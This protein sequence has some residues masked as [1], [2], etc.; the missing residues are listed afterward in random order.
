MWYHQHPAWESCPLWDIPACFLWIASTSFVFLRFQSVFI[1]LPKKRKNKQ[2]LFM[3]FVFN[4]FN[5][6]L[7]QP[8]ILAF[9]FNKQTKNYSQW[10]EMHAFF[11]RYFTDNFRK[12]IEK[13]NSWVIIIA[14]F[15]SIQLSLL[16]LFPHLYLLVS[17]SHLILFEFFGVSF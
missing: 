12:S 11:M 5:L 17:F 3:A 14:Y 1:I 10:D 9:I 15:T 4:R 7:S 16:V 13:Q 8:H 2:I 6:T